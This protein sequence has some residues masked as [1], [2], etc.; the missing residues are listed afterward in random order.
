MPMATLGYLDTCC[1]IESPNIS[2]VSELPIFSP[3]FI[4]PSSVPSAI[5]S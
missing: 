1:A 4:V 2:V 5:F 3:P